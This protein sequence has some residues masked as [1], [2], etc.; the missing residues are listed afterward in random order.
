LPTVT[1]INPNIGSVAGGAP[2]T[3]TGTN[4]TTT[5]ETTVTI[6]GQPLANKVVQNA[7]TIT[8]NTPPNTAGAKDVVV[9]NSNGTA[10]LTGGFTYSA[11]GGTT[12][13][14]A[15]AGPDWSGPIAHIDHAHVTLDGRN[16]FD[17]DA[18]VG[19][20]VSY[21]WNEG[22]PS[23][24][25]L[26]QNAI[27]SIQF[28]LGTHTVWLTV[29]DDTGLTDSDDVRI[30]VTATAEN[31]EK[32]YCNDPNDDGVNNSGDLLIMASAYGKRFTISGY[33]SGY[34]RLKDGNGDRIINSADFLVVAMY[35]GTC[36]E[37]DRMI[38]DAT[39]AMETY[40]IPPSSTGIRTIGFQDVRNAIA[41]GYVQ[42]TPYIPGQGRHMLRG[43]GLE[44]NDAV[45]DLLF[46]ES[47]LY[48]PDSTV[49]GGWRLGAPMFVIPYS[50]TTNPPGGTSG[51]IP[52]E[53]FPGN[54]DAWHY[55][56]NLCV[57]GWNGSGYQFV[58]EN[59]SQSDCLSRPGNPVWT[60]K[61]GWLLHVWNFL[62]NPAGRMVEV[63]NNF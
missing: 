29:T 24:P 11:G 22:S 40:P 13:P 50:L 39:N 3:I 62:P 60:P 19:F 16:S 5:A 20:I 54:E 44:G 56:N 34:S 42:V 38:R 4:F 51:G 32:F 57:W 8:G 17:P 37:T 2:V 52:P 35:F 46:P 47:L 41:V 43:G 25:L 33:D 30:T 7:T 6:G 49:P 9:T 59:V 12:P 23:G 15:D 1:G 26:S 14:V 28:T 48:E 31:P 55:H 63:N 27:D 53:G 61:A 10:T 21:R 36:S 45:M 18:P 58:A